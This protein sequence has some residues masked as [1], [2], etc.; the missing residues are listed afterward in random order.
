M[1]KITHLLHQPHPGYTK[2]GYFRT[3]AGITIV[4]FL[5]LAI[6]Q[7][8]NIGDRNI[9]GNPY[10]TALIYAGGAAITMS[11]SSLWLFLLPK[12]F[13]RKNWTLGK[14]LPVLVYQMISI[15]I[16]IW[17][18]NI[19]RGT[20]PRGDATFSRSL[21]LVIA[22]GILPYILAT[23]V[24]HIYLLRNNL[25]QAQQMNDRLKSETGLHNDATAFQMPEKAVVTVPKLLNRILL[26]EFIYAESKGNN[27][28]IQCEVNGIL[29]QHSVRCTLNEFSLA[30]KNNPQLFRCHRS[31]IINTQKILRVEG[32]AAGYQVKLHPELPGIVVARSNV[33]AFKKVLKGE[34]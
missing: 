3:V 13:E 20:V 22:I 25:Q 6:F 2:A 16:T 1:K 15:A 14:E 10:L 33:E 21:F 23:F 9:N 31:F 29:F 17:L 32:N 27:L 26:D 12:W 24:K 11:V 5:I 28:L 7:P 30:N 19:F 4:V 18:I 8:F 34:P